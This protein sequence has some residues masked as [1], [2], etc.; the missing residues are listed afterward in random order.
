MLNDLLLPMFDDDYYPQILVA[1][2]KQYIVDFSKKI[3]VSVKE[4]SEIY[5]FANLTLL[6]INEMKAEF[7]DLD[8]SLDDTATDYIAEAMMMVVQNA[9]YMDI[10][11]EELV[12]RREW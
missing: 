4:E 6:K 12:A 11:L 9:G 7:E 1:E 2:I 10:D 3:Q 8:S 5:Q